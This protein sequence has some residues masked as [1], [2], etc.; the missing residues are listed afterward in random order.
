MCGGGGGG[1]GGGSVLCHKCTT[2]R[3]FCYISNSGSNKGRGVKRPA[4]NYSGDTTNTVT[5]VC[6]CDQDA[7]Q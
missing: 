6:N 2:I 7:V 4:D 1:G 3:M 5:V